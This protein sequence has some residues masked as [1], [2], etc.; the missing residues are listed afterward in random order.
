MKLGLLYRMGADVPEKNVTEM[1]DLCERGGFSAISPKAMDG[2]AWE[3][4]F[5][6]DPNLGIDNAAE[7]QAQV[8]AYHQRGI[9]VEPWV[10]Y[11]GF[12]A[13]AEATAHA[14]VGRICRT[15]IVDFEWRYPGFAD[16]GNWDDAV[17][18]FR[19][20]REGAPGVRIVFCPDARQIRRGE[21]QVADVLPFVD[22]VSPQVYWTDFQRPWGE[23]LDEG[24]FADYG[25]KPVWPMV[26]G[27]SDPGDLDAALT[28]LLNEAHAPG[29]ATAYVFQRVGLREEN[30]A[31]LLKHSQ[32]GGITLPTEEESDMPL[33]NVDKDAYEAD[34]W[35]PLY[36]RQQEDAAMAAKL[37]ATGHH[38]D[39]LLADAIER[40]A[41]VLQPT[42][43]LHKVVCGA[44]AA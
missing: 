11:R 9:D 12:D 26:P 5:D 3:G 44:E 8:L 23:V 2:D 30:L 10:V 35:A 17:R 14:T 13:G 21:Y 43:S 1:A 36:R 37:R 29:P 38:A 16:K 24:L 15:L 39:A 4:K 28:R 22:V 27:N 18:Y 6:N 40:A 42:V 7:L 34:Y 19:L 41:G 20:L 31:V 33:L 25:G 32:L